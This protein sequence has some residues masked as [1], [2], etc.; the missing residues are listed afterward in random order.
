MADNEDRKDGRRTGEIDFSD[1]QEVEAWLGQVDA[2]LDDSD[3]LALA[4]EISRQFRHAPAVSQTPGPQG[5]L[6]RTQEGL[7]WVLEQIE[8]Q[9]S[10]DVR[11]QLGQLREQIIEDIEGLKQRIIEVQLDDP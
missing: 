8:T 2:H 6:E 5:E 7:S 11:L 4:E 1:P 3:R 9:E 10:A